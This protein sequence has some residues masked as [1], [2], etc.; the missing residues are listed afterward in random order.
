MAKK[1]EDKLFPKLSAG[2][3]YSKSLWILCG[4][5]EEDCEDLVNMQY[6]DYPDHQV[7]GNDLRILETV[8][9][10]DFII[11]YNFEDKCVKF[12]G[13]VLLNNL[14]KD[15]NYTTKYRCQI[16]WKEIP[17]V[18]YDF[19][20]K[21][22]TEDMILITNRD[23][24]TYWKVIIQNKLLN[25]T[26]MGDVKCFK[27]AEQLA[28]EKGRISPIDFDSLRLYFGDVTSISS[29]EDFLELLGQKLA[30]NT[31]IS[32]EEIKHYDNTIHEYDFK[33]FF[34]EECL[35]FNAWLCRRKLTY[36]YENP[37]I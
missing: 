25:Q 28:K 13:K 19:H 17:V 18:Y 11:L 12:I 22:F 20:L 9:A 33:K 36:N 7:V 6:I 10:S 1:R 3:F 26:P 34:K 35:K 30:N 15:R 2:A 32:E 4:E 8:D 37:C 24:R 23:R 27:T 16:K 29:R 14:T 5:D 31:T 21:E